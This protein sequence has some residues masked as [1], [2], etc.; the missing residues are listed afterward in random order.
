MVCCGN[1]WVRGGE[2][3]K[4]FI[5]RNLTAFLALYT[6]LWTL[7]VFIPDA[8]TFHSI[9]KGNYETPWY[10]GNWI[11]EPYTNSMLYNK[12]K[13]ESWHKNATGEDWFIREV[14]YDGK[15]I[16]WTVLRTGKGEN[17]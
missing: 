5:I 10:N 17:I 15:H 2:R 13:T 3:M 7:F 11:T 1:V 12:P 4:A 8:L 6:I 16:F 9:V 14:N